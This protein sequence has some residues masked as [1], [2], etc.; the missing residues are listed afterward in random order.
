LCE[1]SQFSPDLTVGAEIVRAVGGSSRGA[2]QNMMQ[3]FR[4]GVR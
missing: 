3:S 2:C 4:L 1:E